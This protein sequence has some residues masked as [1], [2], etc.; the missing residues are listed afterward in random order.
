MATNSYE[1]ARSPEELIERLRRH[2]QEYDRMQSQ[3]QK[4]SPAKESV[5][6]MPPAEL[7]RPNPAGHG[8][9][10][11]TIPV[12]SPHWFRCVSE[13]TTL[14]F[15]FDN[16]LSLCTGE[17]CKRCP[18]ERQLYGY[19]DAIQAKKDPATGDKVWARFVQALTPSATGLLEGQTLRG[20]LL[21]LARARPNSSTKVTIRPEPC[22]YPLP[23]PVDLKAV[24]MRRYRLAAW[25]VQEVA[26]ATPEQEDGAT[27]LKFRKIG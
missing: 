24:L 21:E 25:P 16:G 8:L 6:V 19:I 23:D 18:G 17:G 27:I 14:L 26:E 4:E 10:I 1:P 2:G 13:M 9:P 22:R 3:A 5:V 20:R 15:H 7:Y 11:E 12:R